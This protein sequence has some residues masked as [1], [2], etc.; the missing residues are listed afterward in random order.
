GINGGGSGR[1]PII[2][3]G[4]AKGQVVVG[5]WWLIS[6]EQGSRVR[7]LVS[8]DGGT[9]EFDRRHDED[10]LGFT[11]DLHQPRWW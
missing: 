2:V 4:S 10:T 3:G 8:D 7:V 11:L 5:L 9:V 1:I 6:S